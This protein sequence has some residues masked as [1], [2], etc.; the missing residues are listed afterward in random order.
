MFSATKV[1]FALLSLR[2]VVGHNARDI[3]PVI[4]QN[5]IIMAEFTNVPVSDETAREKFLGSSAAAVVNGNSPFIEQA[6]FTDLRIDVVKTAIDGTVKANARERLVFKT[7]Q[8]HDISLSMLFATKV[9][10]AEGGRRTYVKPSGTW[11]AKANAILAAN[12]NITVRELGNQLIAAA[13]R[14]VRV[15]RTPYTG[16]TS[17]SREYPTSVVGFDII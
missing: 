15:V 5:L 16:I 4:L 17:D 7:T 13:P 8:G 14:G 12:P 10:I 1:F 9:A 2:V 6:T 3:F 11:V